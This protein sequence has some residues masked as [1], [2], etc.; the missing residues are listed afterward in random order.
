MEHI[1]TLCTLTIYIYYNIQDSYSKCSFMLKIINAGLCIKVSKNDYA[2][3]LAVVLFPIFIRVLQQNSA[4]KNYTYRKQAFLADPEMDSQGMHAMEE[5]LQ[6]EVPFQLGIPASF[7]LHEE[8]V[9]VYLD[10]EVE[11]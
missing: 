3:L 1:A 8:A 4:R 6:E 9:R 7:D 5:M 2:Q 10:Q 11:M